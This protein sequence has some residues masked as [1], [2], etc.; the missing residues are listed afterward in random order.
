MAIKL[1][2]FNHKG[3]V[4]K[5]TLSSNVARALQRSGYEVLLIDADPQCNLSSLHLSEELLDT[6]LDESNEDEGGNTI[7]S[8]LRPVVRG[9]GDIVEVDVYG[10]D[11]T[12]GVVAGD[13]LLADYERALYKEWSGCFTGDD[14][15]YDVVSALSRVTNMIA[16]EDNIN[17]DFVIY[18][19]GPN[20]GALNK[21]VLL[22]SDYFIVP[23]APDLF[24]LRALSAVGKSV[25]NWIEEWQT[26]KKPVRKLIK[27]EPKFLGYVTSAFKRYR[28]K[29][30]KLTNPHE[31]WENRIGVRVK[32]KLVEPLA[33]VSPA[34]ILNVPQKIGQVQNYQS[35]ASK[36]M[37]HRV[38]IGELRKLVHPNYYKQV[39]NAAKEFD[40]I[41][42]E[43]LKRTGVV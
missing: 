30:T 38:G 32:N 43:I 7:W 18:D 4:G 21:I 34:S 25:S 31:Y 19:V 15:A 28:R 40:A 3:G 42:Q 1:T 13:V 33:A 24:S 26:A 11:D 20:I 27:G 9:K 41:A 36:A 29:H 22:D 37:K 23:L 39:D 16:S 6:L 12:P 5:S 14:R 8:A 2:F 35:L 10:S 17:A